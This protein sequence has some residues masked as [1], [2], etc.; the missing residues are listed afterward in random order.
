MEDAQEIEARQS[1]SG[2]IV[3]E[4]I[5]REGEEELA[6]SSAA[7]GWS[8]LAAGLSIGFSMIA[9]GLRASY[10]PKSGWRRMVAKLGYS[11]AF[12]VVIRVRQQLFTENTLTPILP[13]LKPRTRWI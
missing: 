10:L 9:E 4:A 6:R 11:V 8:G 12:V 13:L 1:P 7:L 5:A 3:F 2:K